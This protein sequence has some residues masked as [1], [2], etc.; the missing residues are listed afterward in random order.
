MKKLL[1]SLNVFLL[2]LSLSACDV[3]RIPETQ[4]TDPAFWK[5]E[6]D[7]QMATNYLY[8]FL[9]GFGTSEVWSDNA[10]G[11]SSD[12]VSDGTRLA[13]ASSEDYAAPYRL[14]RAANSIQ[15]K[16]PA[17]PVA[18]DVQDRYM[19]EARFF[20]ALAYGQLVQK[21]GGV[22][23]ILKT[24]QEDAPELTQA[25]A[26]RQEVMQQVYDD[27]DFAAAALPTP[28]RL[29]GANYG[30]ISNTAALALKARLALFEGTRAKFHQDGDAAPHLALAAAAAKAVMDSKEHSLY[31]SYADLFQYAGEG[32][33]NKETILVK[34][35]GTSQAN[36]VLSH[37]FS[38]NLYTGRM[39]PTKSLVDSYLM[40]D[41]LP[42]EKSPLYSVPSASVEVFSNRDERLEAT[43]FKQGDPYN[44]G[45]RFTTPMNYHKTGFG[46]KKFFNA[47]DF[48][49]RRALLDLALIRYAEVLLT[50]AE[51]TFELNGSI[52][53]ADLVGTIN[54]L[55]Q[56]GQVAPL[57][58]AFAQAN[59]LDMREEIR[60]ERRVELALESQRYW[61]LIRW[62]TAETELPKPVLGNYYFAEEFGVDVPV[63]TNEEG[64]I[65]AQQASF[66]SFDPAKDYLWPLPVNELGL[67]P[68]LR[69]NPNW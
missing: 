9:P 29:G 40:K 26:S 15:E 50:Y 49:T 6:S 44:T 35:Y 43:V 11:T 21:Y 19:A 17:V 62:K 3:E 18:A 56:R 38:E 8:T 10:Y 60:R 14:I 58:N 28:A 31:G 65:V 48:R 22:P 1:T 4:I 32:P 36:I 47:D 27:L 46:P 42:I 54:L 52:S 37:N 16:A 57:S 68:A 67:N 24:L 33:Q 7:L 34:Q 2:L 20:R 23:L 12:P 13:P 51:A 69:Q 55:R 59:G 45:A 61:D 25:A 30:R 41:G 66:R 5:S 64:F 39:N 63:N 53:D